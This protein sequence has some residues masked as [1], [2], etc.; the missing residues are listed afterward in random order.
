MVLFHN[1]TMP[2]IYSPTIVEINDLSKYPLGELGMLVKDSE[3]CSCSE[4]K[5]QLIEIINMINNLIEIL[6]IIGDEDKVVLESL[7]NKAIEERFTD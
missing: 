7:V 3:E 4:I 2:G 5:I 1:D 6:K